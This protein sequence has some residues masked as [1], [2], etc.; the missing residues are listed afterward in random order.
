MTPLAIPTGG[1]GIDLDRHASPPRTCRHAAPVAGRS[2]KQPIRTGEHGAVVRPSP[3]GRDAAQR[4]LLQFT[5][6]PPGQ[7]DP[8]QEP[9]RR[10][11]GR[12]GSGWSGPRSTMSWSGSQRTAERNP[13]RRPGVAERRRRPSISTRWTP[14]PY[15][16]RGLY[17]SVRL[18]SS[19]IASTDSGLSTPPPYSARAQRARSLGVRGEAAG[20]AG[21]GD[22]RGER[23]ERG[24]IGQVD[25]AGVLGRRLEAVAMGDV[26]RRR[27]A[28]G[29]YHVWSRPSGSRKRARTWSAK[30]R[31]PDSLGE[32]AK[33]E[34]VRVRVVPSLAGLEI[35]L[36]HVLH[37]VRAI[38]APVRLASAVARSM[39][40]W[41]K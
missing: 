4:W 39:D 6:A 14:R 5:Q 19:T 38:P 33:D 28:S 34:V 12:S 27:F 18:M 17:G 8:E 9:A 10:S 20:A 7:G 21:G 30:G 31:L 26:R 15:G 24:A 25:G 37:R 40:A 13:S 3:A 41:K 35:R 32:H 2:V 23:H 36:A 22:D 1:V 16:T 11:R 29:W